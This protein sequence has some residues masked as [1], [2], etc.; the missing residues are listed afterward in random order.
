MVMK[1]RITQVTGQE[2]INQIEHIEPAGA[3]AVIGNIHCAGEVVTT[4]TS[5]AGVLVGT[6]SILRIE[7]TAGTFI[8]FGDS[9]I[10][11]V[12]ATTSPAFKHP[13]GYIMINATADWVRT[14]AA[15]TRLEVIKNSR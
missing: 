1:K 6:G 12:D 11:A 4:N 9:N 10:G 13:G 14:S 7:A 2:T 8:A 5:A 15:L 3:R